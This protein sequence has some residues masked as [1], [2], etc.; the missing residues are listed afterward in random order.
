MVKKKLENQDS[1]TP[2]EHYLEKRKDKKRE[3]RKQKNKIE[4]QEVIDYLYVLKAY[5][6]IP[7]CHNL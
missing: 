2:W 7:R 1:L 4:D 5:L 6:F 3:K